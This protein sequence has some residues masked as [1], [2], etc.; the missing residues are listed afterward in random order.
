MKEIFEIFSNR[1]M[2]T[3]IW[4]LIFILFSIVA[5]STRKASGNL[6]YT[7]FNWKIQKSIIY[8]ALY[9]GLIVI[10]FYKIS[11]WNLSMLKDTIFWFLFTALVVLYKGVDNSKDNKLFTKL[12]FENF[13]VVVIVEFVVNMYNF[14]FVFELLIIPIVLLLALID[15]ALK[16]SLV[17]KY[18]F[19]VAN[20]F[21]FILAM[22]TIILTI[23]D[24]TNNK[25]EYLNINTLKSF[26][27][28]II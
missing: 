11:Y 7:F 9:S 8:S 19:S 18:K 3:A 15:E 22:V 4:I 12:I 25:T 13:K 14:S 10:L 1:E 28:P 16:K 2:A 26:L 5:T 20:S 17:N 6:L 23:K 21:T 27:T 24:F